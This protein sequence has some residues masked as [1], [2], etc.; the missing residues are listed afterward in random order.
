MGGLVMGR[1]TSENTSQLN[2]ATLWAAHKAICWKQQMQLKKQKNKKQKTAATQTY[3]LRN[4]FCV[5]NFNISRV[6]LR[7]Y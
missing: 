5:F 4:R 1:V 3:N 7:R 2:M 6:C